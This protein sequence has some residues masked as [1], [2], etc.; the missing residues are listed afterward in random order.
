MK[1]KGPDD[2]ISAMFVGNLKD[3]FDV[4]ISL[5]C[6]NVIVLVLSIFASFCLFFVVMHFFVTDSL[7]HI[8]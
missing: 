8:I 4:Y 1:C 6:I 7:F 3:R 2:L 5:F